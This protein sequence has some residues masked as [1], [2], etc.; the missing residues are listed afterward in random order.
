MTAATEIGRSDEGAHR[1]LWALGDYGTVAAEVVAPLGPVL[2]QASG[3]GAGQ[4][5]L[6]GKHTG[7][8]DRQ[9]TQA[10]DGRQ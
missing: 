2:V 5:R 9:R 6:G 4:P 10:G 7:P 1:A 3:I 8:H